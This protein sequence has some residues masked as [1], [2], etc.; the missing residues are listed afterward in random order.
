MTK[1][2]TELNKSFFQNALAVSQIQE[3]LNIP[4]G[5]GSDSVPD[6]LS[7]LSSAAGIAAGFAGPA[8]GVVGAASGVF[9]IMGTYGPSE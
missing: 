7:I 5:Q 9:S 1:L 6:I 3:L 4:S 2:D 8:G